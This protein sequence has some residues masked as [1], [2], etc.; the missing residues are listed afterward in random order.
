MRSY[1]GWQRE[2]D[3]EAAKALGAR[4]MFPRLRSAAPYADASTDAYV[5]DAGKRH[6]VGIKLTDAGLALWEAHGEG[7]QL[8]GGSPGSSERASDVNKVR[9]HESRIRGQVEQKATAQPK[10]T[11]PKPHF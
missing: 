8:K 5:N 7:Q 6:V 3:G 1:H 10:V 2:Q 9:T 4:G 11:S